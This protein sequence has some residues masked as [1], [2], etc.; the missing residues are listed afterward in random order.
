[1]N[2]TDTESPRRRVPPTSRASLRTK[3][4][5]PRPSSAARRAAFEAVRKARDPATAYAHA[6]VRGA[7]LAGPHVRNSCRRH[8]RDLKEGPKRGLV[9]DVESAQRF[10]GFCAD[11]LK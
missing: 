11:V 4:A 6:V 2:H 3:K 5:A 7:I 1:M 10:I 9:W 8:L